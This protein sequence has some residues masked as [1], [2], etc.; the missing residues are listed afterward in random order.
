MSTSDGTTARKRRIRRNTQADRRGRV[1][2]AREAVRDEVPRS[3]RWTLSHPQLT[4]DKFTDWEWV[5]LNA[6]YPVYDFTPLKNSS[7]I[8]GRIL[9]MTGKSARVRKT[10]AEAERRAYELCYSWD[11]A[12]Q[13]WHAWKAGKGP[14]PRKED[15][16]VLAKFRKRA[17]VKGRKRVSIEDIEFWVD[18][19]D[20]PMDLRPYGDPQD[21]F[22]PR[23]RPTADLDT[24][25]TPDDSESELDM[26]NEDP[27]DEDVEPDDK[28]D[29]GPLVEE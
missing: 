16:D 8:V 14:R 1:S 13:R 26:S 28:D 24:Q 17:G 7:V 15:F 12:R 3:I 6:R 27:E 11:R 19:G 22:T 29:V 21:P 5:V 25:F 23:G 18:L 20:D 10:Q 9:D 2:A 4:Q